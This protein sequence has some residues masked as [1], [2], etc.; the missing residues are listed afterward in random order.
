M[1]HK[2]GKLRKPAAGNLGQE[3]SYDATLCSLPGEAKARRKSPAGFSGLRFILT[4]L[5]RNCHKDGDD[6][7][8]VVGLGFKR[9][10]HKNGGPHVSSTSSMSVIPW[11]SDYKLGFLVY[12]ARGFTQLHRTFISQFRHS[13]SWW[14]VEP[15]PCLVASCHCNKIACVRDTMSG[16][17]KRSRMRGRVERN[18]NPTLPPS[19]PIQMAMT[20]L[21]ILPSL[22]LRLV[23]H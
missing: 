21:S 3:I 20:S 8:R 15:L 1:R 22:S 16:R 7:K 19:H 11:T 12:S 14:A 2:A 9:M 10:S 17:G 6:D 13:C 23:F 18:R 5:K 4:E